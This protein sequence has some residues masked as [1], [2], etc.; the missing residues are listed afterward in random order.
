MPVGHIW[1]QPRHDQARL[2]PHP[3]ASK[4]QRSPKPHYELPATRARKG[5]TMD[6][7]GEITVLKRLLCYSASG[8]TAMAAEPW[9]NDVSAYTDRERLARE[10]MVLF[11]KHPIVMGLS[12]DWPHPGTYRTDDWAGVPMLIVRG[13]D[14]KI[15]A[16]LNVCRHR[17]A[18]VATGDGRASVFSCPYHAWTYG[19]DGA[20]RGIP[21]ER[22]FPGVREGRTGLVPL[23]VAERYGLVWVL[24]TPAGPEET[25]L[26]IEPWLGGMG[27]DLAHW[28]LDTYHHHDRRLVRDEMNWKILVDTFH[29]GYHIGFLHRDSLSGILHGNI[30]DFVPFG[31]NHRVI[32]PRKKLAKLNDLPQETWDLMWNTAIVYCLFPNTL[33]FVQG[34]HVEVNRIFP[35][36]DRVDR[37]VMEA[38]LY[39]P[40]PLA[41]DEERQ[42]WDANMD[43]LMNV[44]AN[45][46]FPAGR[47]MQIGF[48]SGAQRDVVYGR[49]EPAMIH[50]HRAMREALGMTL[51]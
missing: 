17:G 40:K 9:R 48:D 11:R 6:K 39:I 47:T 43:L 24:P 19:L 25:D 29:E 2:R 38:A 27:P 7:S 1:K 35:L 41:N 22:A 3:G 8:T 18:K 15:R 20:I 13:A 37:A 44:V 30:A 16:F 21:D 10:R 36:E 26:D 49:N 46:D 31:R 14:R 34:D 45:E 50:Y 51:D 28:Q 23:P 33:L 32:F 42:H 5:K 12:C 4:S